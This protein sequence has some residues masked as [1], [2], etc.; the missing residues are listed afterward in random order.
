[1]KHLFIFICLC[2]TGTPLLAQSL[3]EEVSVSFS[4]VEKMTKKKHYFL[5]T[6]IITDDSEGFYVI[7]TPFYEL[8]K[9]QTPFVKKQPYRLVR[10]TKDMQ[11]VTLLHLSGQ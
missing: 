9:D 3:K 2:L 1:M 8:Y 6:A 11:E 10:F 5:K 7:G 4:P